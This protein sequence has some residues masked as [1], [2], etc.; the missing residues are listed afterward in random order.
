MESPIVVIGIFLFVAIGT[1]LVSH[2][3]IKTYLVAS[4]M[5]GFLSS[6]I[7]Q[8]VAYLYAGYLDPFFVVA[9]ITGSIASFIIALIVGYPFVGKRKG[10]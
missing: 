10:R 9:F 4:V 1:S 5:A 6:L 7:Y 3:L 8:I 2:I